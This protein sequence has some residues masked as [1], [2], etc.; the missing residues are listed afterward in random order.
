MES[1]DSRQLH[2]LIVLQA[3]PGCW[4]L[5]GG[6]ALAKFG[7]DSRIPMFRRHLPHF[8]TQSS[9]EDPMARVGVSFWDAG[10][11]D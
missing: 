1:V 4:T 3:D 6:V 11:F 8:R 7:K 9:S 2:N 5:K 10:G